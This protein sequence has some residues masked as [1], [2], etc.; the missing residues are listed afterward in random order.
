L[1][2]SPQYL[3]LDFIDGSSINNSVPVVSEKFS[4]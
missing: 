3:I 4:L 2:F 1:L